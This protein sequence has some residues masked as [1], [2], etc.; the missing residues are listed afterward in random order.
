MLLHGKFFLYKIEKRQAIML[1]ATFYD[2][3]CIVFQV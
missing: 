1:D 3:D 2:F